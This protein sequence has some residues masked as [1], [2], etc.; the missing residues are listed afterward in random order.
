MGNRKEKK[1][2]LEVHGRII[3]SLGIQMYQSPVAA[4]AELIANAWDA[5]A[6]VVDVALPNELDERAEIV[7]KDNGTGMTFADCQTHYLKIGRNR[8]VDE[9][10]TTTGGRPCLGRKGIGKFAGFGIA[11]MIEIDTI[12]GQTGEHTAFC[13]DLNKLRTAEFVSTQ[14]QEV[15]ILEAS[16]PREESRAEHGTVVRLR[17]LKLSQRRTPEA[18][19]R[20]M[21][22]RFLLARVAADF[23][24]TINGIALPAE[25]EF[26]AFEFEFPR[27]YRE[28]EAPAGMNLVDGWGR[29]TLQDGN[30]LR[31]RVRFTP[32]PIGVEEF[33]GVSVFCGIKVAQTPFFFQLSG[34]LSGQHGQQYISGIVQAD[35][36]D[37]SARDVITTERQR[38]NWEDPI[39]APLLTWGQARLRDLL[40][41]WKERRA[42]SKIQVIDARI[43]EFRERLEKLNPSEEK[44]VRRALT[45][46]A[47]IEAIDQ[48]QFVALAGAILT[49]WEGG[50]LRQIIEDVAGMEE[51]DAGVLLTL[52]AEH[53][54]LTALHVAEAV[55]LKVDVIAGLRHRIAQR[56]IETAIRDYI[57]KHPWLVSPK[58][59]TF[60]VERRVDKL[61]EDALQESGI[62]NDV[63]WEGRVDLCLAGGRELLVLEFMRPGLQVDRNHIDR[64]QRYVDILRSRVHANSDLGLEHITG[65]LVADKL[66][67]RPE[68]AGAIERMARDGMF[69]QEWEI[70]LA[71]AASQWSEFLDVLVERSPDDA[72]VKELAAK[73]KE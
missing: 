69:C 64:F 49:A 61:V 16:E 44:T 5:D 48:E 72:R 57:A 71:N 43:A 60:R 10:N 29:E 45:R 37:R 33:R 27:D 51:M 15:E 70:L 14:P 17:S 53:Q 1:L 46:I 40:A 65:L 9:G 21:A 3:D 8:R 12:S 67:R 59:E 35:Y 6:T 38:V 56:E 47:S 2:V 50:R 66:H 52:L 30:E 20:Q 22:R 63:D 68:D 11:D 32:T 31:W 55:K 28:G 39:A 58:W 54:V 19:A 73:P 36:I 25:E 24:V 23:Q 18:L 7:I 41:I 26:A 4:I 42:E 13:L 34:G 62:A